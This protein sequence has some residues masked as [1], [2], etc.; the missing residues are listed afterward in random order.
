METRI[1]GKGSGLDLGPPT[2]SRDPAVC[3]TAWVQAVVHELG[4]ITRILPSRRQEIGENDECLFRGMLALEA[5]RA[6]A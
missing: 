5:Q 6:I 4:A 1:A 3:A 2:P